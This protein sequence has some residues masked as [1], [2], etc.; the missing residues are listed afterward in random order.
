[1][2]SPSVGASAECLSIHVYV[3]SSIDS[4][5]PAHALPMASIALKLAS[6]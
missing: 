2:S 6:V 5:A 1:M 3:A 4:P